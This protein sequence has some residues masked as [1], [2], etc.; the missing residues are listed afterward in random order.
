MQKI[1]PKIALFLPVDKIEPQAL[2]QI[3]NISEMPFVRG[4]VAVMPDCHLGKGA[5]IGTVIGTKGAVI[6]AAV[7][8]D[9]G[10]GM[11]AVRTN[12]TSALVEGKL[13]TIL[14]GLQRRIPMSAGKFNTKILPSAEL[15]I[16]ELRDA[17]NPRQTKFIN[18]ISPNWPEQL[19]TLGGGNHFIELCVD[20]NGMIWA[21]LHSGSRGVGNKIGNHYIKV[22][23]ALCK[24]MWINLKDP[25]LAYLPENTEA[26]DHYIEDLRWAQMFARL[27]RDEMMDRFLEELRRA[28]FA[29]GELSESISLELERINC[30]HN[31]TQQEHHMGH[32]VWLTRKG[33]IEASAGKLGMIP[34]SMGTRSYIVAGLGNPMSYNSAPHGAGRNFSR[35]AARAKFTME[36]F[37]RDMTGIVHRRSEEFLDEIPGAYKDIDEVMENAKELVQ[38]LYVLKQILNAKG[39]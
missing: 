15:R 19:G 35:A 26:F 2:E 11:I 30:H 36:D 14:T 38:I 9:I 27:N 7:G 13:E 3:H 1:S 8:V 12:I 32:D 21:T 25:D 34:G 33:A 18:E 28:V 24:S 6:P 20:T 37:D 29:E 10:C 31:F 5:T 22:A 4:H 17:M 23:Q 16:R 39:N